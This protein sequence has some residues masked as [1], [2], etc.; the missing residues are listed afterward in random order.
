MEKQTALR[1]RRLLQ[2]RQ[3]WQ[4][5]KRSAQT[6]KR[7]GSASAWSSLYVNADVQKTRDALSKLRAITFHPQ[8]ET[9]WPDERCG[10]QPSG[11]Q[12]IRSTELA[13]QSMDPENPA[14]SGVTVD[15]K[16]SLEAR[17][18]I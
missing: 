6:V 2:P 12:W 11:G 17:R 8:L 1:Y 15:F 4:Q 18:I 16:E 10:P 3:Q 7:S 9:Q 14:Q 5:Q 13:K